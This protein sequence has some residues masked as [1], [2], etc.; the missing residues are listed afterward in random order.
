MKRNTPT[1][2]IATQKKSVSKASADR[3]REDSRAV[4]IKRD[5]NQRRIA[6]KGNPRKLAEAYAEREHDV[7]A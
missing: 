2:T 3:G 5:K 7:D 1:G 6:T 4:E